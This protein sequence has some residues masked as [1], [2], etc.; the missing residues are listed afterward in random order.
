[1]V[2]DS[3]VGVVNGLLVLSSEVWAGSSQVLISRRARG[4]QSGAAK[5]KGKDIYAKRNLVGGGD[6][7]ALRESTCQACRYMVAG[8]ILP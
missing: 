1:V 3:C 7:V 6:K 8:K 4:E 2:D 5:S